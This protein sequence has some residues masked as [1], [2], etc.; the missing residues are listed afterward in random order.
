L[1]FEK[2][3][4]RLFSARSSGK[5]TVFVIAGN[6]ARNCYVFHR[7][8]FAANSHIKQGSQEE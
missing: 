3:K 2:L 6:A 4:N 8:F 1:I 7:L 5:R